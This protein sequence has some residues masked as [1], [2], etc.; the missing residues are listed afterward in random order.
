MK[1][2]ATISGERQV[3]TVTGT[4]HTTTTT[5]TTS[6]AST[7]TFSADDMTQAGLQSAQQALNDTA[8]DDVDYDKVAQMQA[9]LAAGDMQIDPDRLASDMLAFFQK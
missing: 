7:T 9:M 3:P 8:Q 4:S 6:V 5:A 2:T 1:I